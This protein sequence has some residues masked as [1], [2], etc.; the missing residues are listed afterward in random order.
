LPALKSKAYFAKTSVQKN[1]TILAAFAALIILEGCKDQA[2]RSGLGIAGHNPLLVVGIDGATW[3]VIDPMIAA[4]ELPNI[5]RLRE[6]G[7]WG[8][9]I[10]VGPQVS[11]VVWTTFGTGRFGRQHGIL[12]FVYPY[13]PGPKRP[14]QT[15]ERQSPALWNLVSD[16]GGKVGVVGY[17]VTY[18]AEEI[19]GA[20]VSY[21]SPQRQP[22]ADYPEDVLAPVRN[23]LDRVFNEDR[24]A[25]WA[26]F[27]PWN[28]NPKDPPAED[29]PA[30]EAFRM[31]SGRVERR[32]LHA[33]YNRRASLHL[34][35]SPH[36]LFISYFGLVDH[37]SHA[38]WKYYDD[39]DYEVKADPES[40]KL[41]GQAVPEAYRYMDDF[42]G[43]LLAM[44][45]ENANIVIISDHG[46]GSATGRFSVK[47]HNRDR[48][49]GNHRPNGILLAAGPDFSAGRIDGLTI[50]D[51]FPALAYL[52]GVAVADDLPGDLDLRLFTAER[53][54]QAPPTFTRAYASSDPKAAR[55]TGA[56]REAQEDNIKA[57]Q[58]LGYVGE[59]FEFADA[60]TGDFDFWA[61]ERELVTRHLVG[62][63]SFHAL[64]GNDDGARAI[65]AQARERDESLLPKILYRS[66]V[67]LHSIRDMIGPQ[68]VPE[69]AFSL[70]DAA[71]SNSESG[72]SN[73]A[74]D[75][76]N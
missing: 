69:S 37:A 45:P 35:A 34:A 1:L 59:S 17:F 24:K 70:I 52:S 36:D 20:M 72:L 2:D 21:K 76:G 60:E 51:V 8:P 47:E 53:L 15:T 57:L 43:D 44:S 18:P 39:S 23:E 63:F 48:L 4:G 29:D 28:F 30:A 71:K 6:R 50:M 11:P 54:A 61:A 13:Q 27:L 5:A 31:V 12:D 42:I 64:K 41:L 49:T 67:S 9:L 73:E 25:L 32:I 68:A 58:G 62:E 66:E 46:F 33:E 74:V 38:L 55:S 19:N 3:D 56:S 16:A 40:K 7:A 14:V 10:T 26:R 65:L 75:N 22:G